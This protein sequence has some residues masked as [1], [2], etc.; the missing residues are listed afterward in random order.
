MYPARGASG[1]QGNP[2]DFINHGQA[3]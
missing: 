3:T 2:F 1:A